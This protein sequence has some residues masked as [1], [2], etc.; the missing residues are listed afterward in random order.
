[1]KILVLNG[2]PRAH[3]NTAAMVE[4]F[5]RGARESGNEVNVFNVCRMRIG[6]CMACEYCHIRDSGHERQC[7]QNDDMQRIYPLLD[8]ADMIVLASPIYYHSISGQ[9]QC[10]INRIYALDR[11]LH[12]KKAAL[13][14]SS[15]DSD[16][17]EGAIYEYRRSFLEYLH[18]ENMGIFTA[19][20]KQN[21]SE[22]K[23]G[24]LYEFG[25][26]LNAESSA[27]QDEKGKDELTDEKMDEFV[28][29]LSSGQTVPEG[30]EMMTI[31]TLLSQR[32]L[33]LT[34][35]LNSEYHT[36]DEIRKIFARLTRTE[37][38]PTFNLF[39]P[40]STDCGINLKVGRGVFTNAGCRFQ[41][42]GGIVI[43]DG[44]LIG[45]NVVMATLNHD[46][47]PSKR[48]DIIP[49]PIHIGK[50]VWIGAGAVILAGVSIGNN[51][52]VAAGA[53]VRK[54]VAP[55]T[56]VGGVPARVLRTLADD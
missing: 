50:N 48:H 4:Q 25:K 9:L 32:A 26:S 51:A 23:L 17:Y 30:S 39:P 37:P 54:D 19:H 12:L 29:V 16:V 49:A 45:Q 8:E 31:S 24:E 40:F 34:T 42:Q 47:T 56:V 53:V 10:A 21:R 7:V 2:S 1:M 46:L 18:L 27:R 5:V 43:D 15:G 28:R 11:P 38:D 44:S 41:D 55:N 3:G 6:G 20:G 52:V 14:L 13:I 33:K 35:R 22:E 36:P